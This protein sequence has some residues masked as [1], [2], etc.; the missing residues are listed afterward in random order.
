MSSLSEL[1]IPSTFIP[2]IKYRIRVLPSILNQSV[3]KT[4][5]PSLQAFFQL[6]WNSY[7]EEY[8]IMPES[9]KPKAIKP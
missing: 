2:N 5:R 3:T 8:W 7:C 6:D 4:V 1:V 9:S